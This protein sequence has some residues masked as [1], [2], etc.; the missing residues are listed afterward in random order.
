M[1]QNSGLDMI[2][3]T[4]THLNGY[5]GNVTELIEDCNKIKD[6]AKYFECKAC[7]ENGTKPLKECYLEFQKVLWDETQQEKFLDM[8]K[9]VH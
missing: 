1:D 9:S 4:A 7:Y 8:I 6:D 3:L 2:N 5:F